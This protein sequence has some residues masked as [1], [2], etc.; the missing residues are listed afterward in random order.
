MSDALAATLPIP[1]GTALQTLEV[2]NVKA[3]IKVLIQGAS[4]L[5]GAFA[6]QF[7]KAAGAAVYATASAENEEYVRDLGADVFIDYQTQRFED[8]VKGVDVVLDYVQI[9]GVDNTTDRSWKVLK[10]GGTIV[11]VADPTSQVTLLLDITASFHGL[12]LV[13]SNWSTLQLKLWRGKS[14][15]VSI[16]Y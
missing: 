16:G 5:V 12:R 15:P 6:V 2:G 14:S 3:G 7:A 9:G 10:H 8:L 4:G 13:L 11:S 1:A